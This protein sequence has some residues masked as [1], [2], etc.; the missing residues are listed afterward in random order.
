MVALAM[1]S[2]AALEAGTPAALNAAVRA[3][4]FDGASGPVRLVNGLGDRF[5][6][7][8]GLIFSSW[9]IGTDGRL[10]LGNQNSIQ[11]RARDST[12]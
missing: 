7:G 6:D 11:S 3:Q 10:A 12:W 4:Q 5:S 1:T 9:V 2:A 8:L